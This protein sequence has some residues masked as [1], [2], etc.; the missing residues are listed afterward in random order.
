MYVH[1]VLKLI[2]YFAWEDQRE[3]QGSISYIALC[4]GQY[5]AWE[6]GFQL[7][8]EPLFLYS[9]IQSFDPDKRSAYLYSRS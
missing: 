9:N 1:E 3:L 2:Y 8:F 5:L 7:F 4:I 6:S